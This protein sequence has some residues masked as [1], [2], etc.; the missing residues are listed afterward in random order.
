MSERKQ[1]GL[2]QLFRLATKYYFTVQL[3]ILIRPDRVNT[4][5]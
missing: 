5:S 2:M 4:I 1:H 3:V